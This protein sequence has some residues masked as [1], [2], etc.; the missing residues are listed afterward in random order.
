MVWVTN[1]EI[2]GKLKQKDWDQM[3]NSQRLIKLKK[4]L[5]YTRL[6][7]YWTK[8]HLRISSLKILIGRISNLLKTN[9]KNRVIQKTFNSSIQS[10]ISMMKD[11]FAHIK[12]L[13][14]QSL[15]QKFRMLLSNSIELQSFLNKMFIRLQISQSSFI[16]TYLLAPFQEW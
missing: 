9:I 8:A 3:K 1:F 16:I 4:V 6:K 15:I 5:K 12:T 2:I 10:K 13:N 7:N 14:L 11:L